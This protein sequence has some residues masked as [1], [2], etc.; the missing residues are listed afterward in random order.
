MVAKVSNRVEGI[1]I[2]RTLRPLIPGSAHNVQIVE[3]PQEA[4]T[5]GRFRAEPSGAPT[6][7]G[8][9]EKSC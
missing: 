6:N 4:P 2:V 8:N 7:A 5:E 1:P 3:G 9:R